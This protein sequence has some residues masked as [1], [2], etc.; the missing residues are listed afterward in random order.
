[1]C[2][3]NDSSHCWHYVSIFSVHLN[4]RGDTHAKTQNWIWNGMKNEVFID[5][6]GYIDLLDAITHF[7]IEKKNECVL[8]NILYGYSISL[9]YSFWVC[10]F[11]CLFVCIIWSLLLSSVL[12]NT[13]R[14]VFIYTMFHLCSFHFQGHLV[15]ISIVTSLISVRS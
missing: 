15:R 12:A 2:V 7:E 13:P 11:V 3:N 14:F 9:H 1:V 10:L 6:L 4:N 8:H 5:E